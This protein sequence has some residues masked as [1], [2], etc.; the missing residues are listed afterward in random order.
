MSPFNLTKVK[1][2][3]IPLP[4]VIKRVTEAS[5][6]PK[7]MNK[8][9]LEDIE[10]DKRKRRQA[11]TDM[12]RRE[13]ENGSVQRFALATEARPSATKGEKVKEALELEF[14]KG[15]HFSDFKPRRMPDFS[16]TQADVKLN[17][18]VLKREKQ[19]LDKD[20]SSL[21]AHIR[22]MEMGLKDASEFNRWQREMD[23][24]DDIK[25]IEYIQMKK[26]EMELAREQAHQ[27][28]QNNIK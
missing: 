11:T 4:E 25:R 22:G 28:Q 10:T 13:Y 1:P 18:A 24:R 9:T 19:L 21:A 15:L 16:K 20:E 8:I 2:K 17:V 5:P 23:Q 7:N 27:A 12:I 26:I 14:L 3:K 6:V